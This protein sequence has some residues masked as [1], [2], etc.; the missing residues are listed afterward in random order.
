MWANILWR[1][2]HQYEHY[3][4]VTSGTIVCEYKWSF[5]IAYSLEY[6]GNI[7]RSVSYSSTA[8]AS[9]WSTAC[10][11]SQQYPPTKLRVLTAPVEWDTIVQEGSHRSSEPECCGYSQYEQY[12]TLKYR[13]YVLCAVPPVSPSESTLLPQLVHDLSGAFDNSIWSIVV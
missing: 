6:T 13:Q 12:R 3:C 10:E 9:S 2:T 8:S 7:C 5:N 4:Y 1:A 11:C